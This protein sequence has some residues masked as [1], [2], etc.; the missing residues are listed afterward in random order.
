MALTLTQ[1]LA[2][3]LRGQIAAGEFSSGDRLPSMRDLAGQ[4]SVSEITVR[5]ALRAL[6]NEGLVEMRPRVGAIVCEPQTQAAEAMGKTLSGE[7]TVALVLPVLGDPFF[8]RI[9]QGAERECARQGLR[10]LLVTTGGD[11][12]REERELNALSDQV[13]GLIIFPVKIGENAIYREL[14][15]K[16]V[17]IVFLDRQVEG[18]AAPLVGVDNE[19]AG[20]LAGMHLL[21]QGRMVW[22]VSN[23]LGWIAPIDD[24]VRGYRRALAEQGLPFDSSRILQMSGH[25]EMLG[26]ILTR[27]VLALPHSAE[28]FGLLAINDAIA[29]GCYAALQEA[30]VAIPDHAAIVGFGDAWGPM[31]DPPLSAVWLGEE[32]WGREAVALLARAFRG[33]T[34]EAPAPIEP[35]FVTRGSCGANADFCP[36]TALIESAST[37]YPQANTSWPPTPATLVAGSI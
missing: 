25:D 11:I 34:I 15:S 27:R 23:P 26:A 2:S 21:K 28:P 37:T 10:L 20:Y 6:K 17:P 5:G 18:V 3:H 8:S 33:E 36:V 1:K 12:E 13:A 9:A 24:R 30:G 22:V 35:H 7:K 29:R 4:H 31:L 14:E 16:G 19:R 32:N